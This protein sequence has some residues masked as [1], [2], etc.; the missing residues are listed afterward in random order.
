MWRY[1]MDHNYQRDDGEPE[2]NLGR[3]RR[4]GV[5]RRERPYDSPVHRQRN[6]LEPL[7]QPS[8]QGLN[9]V[10]GASATDVFAVGEN[11][12]ILHYDGVT[13]LLPTSGT[14][15]RLHAVWG[16]SGTD[17]FVVGGGGVIR[18]GTR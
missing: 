4:R 6:E 15:E 2:R 1:P 8:A 12:T 7:D 11:G 3:R 10:W 9:G 17:V 5:R 16:S 18:H 13:W 14:T